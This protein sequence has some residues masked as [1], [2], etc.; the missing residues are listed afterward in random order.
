MR[1]QLGLRTRRTSLI[2]IYIYIHVVLKVSIDLRYGG[3]GTVAREH[4]SKP[5]IIL[6]GWEASL[7]R[8]L[9]IHFSRFHP[10]VTICKKVGL[11]GPITD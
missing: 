10:I 7:I 8:K 4:T 3:G 6:G 9:G 2:Y 1:G 5:C 11:E